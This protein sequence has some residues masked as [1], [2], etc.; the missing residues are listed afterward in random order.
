MDAGADAVD[1]AVE[2]LGVA[3]LG[4]DAAVQ[5]KVHVGRVR[6]RVRTPSCVIAHF[7]GLLFANPSYGPASTKASHAAIDALRASAHPT[8]ADE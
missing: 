4:D 3:G 1:D 2:H 8:L 6:A 7:G 5:H